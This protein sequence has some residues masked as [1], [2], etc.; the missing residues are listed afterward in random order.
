MIPKLAE[1]QA[2]YELAAGCV[3]V[4]DISIDSRRLSL[5]RYV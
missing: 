5:E 2:Y 3:A 4:Y 1:F